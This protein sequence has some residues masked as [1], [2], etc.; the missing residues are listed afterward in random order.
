MMPPM[1]QFNSLLTDWAQSIRA[2]IFSVCVFLG[3]TANV[4]DHLT[5]SSKSPFDV[6]INRL[7]SVSL[8]ILAVAT[9]GH[10]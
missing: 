9:G 3:L 5:E 4:T 8:P 1:K 10:V 2:G 6:E 7:P